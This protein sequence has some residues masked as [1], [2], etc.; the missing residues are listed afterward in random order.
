MARSVSIARRFSLAYLVLAGLLGAAVGAFVVLLERPAPKPAPPWS[1]WQPTDKDRAA[2]QQQIAAHVGSQYRTTSGKKLVNVIVRNPESARDSIQE[3]AIARTLQ[4]SKA[5]D[6]LAVIDSKKTAMY[7][8]CGDGPKC[9][10]KEGKPSRAR[11]AVLRREALELALY[12]FRYENDTDSVVAFFP[13]K[14]GNDLTSALFFDKSQFDAELHAPL[15]QTL[16]QGK[17][18][19]PGSLS[20]RERRTIDALTVRRQF[21]F[22]L[23]RDQNG[24]GV[25]VLA[26][27]S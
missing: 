19:V 7:I 2:R 16:P 14:K 11:G 23:R 13:P 25:L 26:P 1:A 6:V 5:G 10:I 17:A 18:P 3:V 15:R 9:S 12:T 24:S 22:I 4:P 20:P 27:G 8:L 21:Q